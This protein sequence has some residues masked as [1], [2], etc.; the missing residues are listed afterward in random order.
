MA[1]IWD[2]LGRA[3]VD[4]KKEYFPQANIFPGDV[5]QA[6][7]GT[8]AQETYGLP[9]QVTPTTTYPRKE[10]TTQ[11]A[12]NPTGS[13]YGSTQNLLSTQTAPDTGPLEST[14]GDVLS[15]IDAA[16]QIGMDALNQY[17]ATIQPSADLQI[18]QAETTAGERTTETETEKARRLGE[19]GGQ[20]T[21][22]ETKTGSAVAEARRMAS[23]LQQGIQ[24]R[25][26]GSSHL[27]GAVSEI[28]GA[29]ATQNISGN[30]AALQE[31]L[32][33][34][35]QAEENVKTAA[36][37]MLQKIQN[38]LSLAKEKALDWVRTAMAQ[39]NSQKAELSGDRASMRMEVIMQYQNTIAQL[40]ETW[41]QEQNAI[42]QKSYEAQN[43]L[44]DF[45]KSLMPQYNTATNKWII[46]ELGLGDDRTLQL[47]PKVSGYTSKVFE[48]DDSK[49]ATVDSWLKSE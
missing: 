36:D 28:M 44:S 8:S 32:G 4:I 17:Q 18:Q 39:V 7:T 20:R 31:T 27:G 47:I 43:Q 34:I 49:P 25:Y 12:Y 14:Q 40:N 9:G 15:E 37:N 41:R 5:T 45:Q 35:G 48:D 1:N 29:Q 16:V 33:K 46:P 3:A 13:T 23:Q 38:N 26:G 19:F 11:T 22:A 42:A 24:A 21:T 10:P 30:R 2:R 6:L